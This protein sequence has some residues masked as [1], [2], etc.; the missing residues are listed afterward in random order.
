[1]PQTKEET[2]FSGNWPMK[3]TFLKVHKNKEVFFK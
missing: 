2:D 1:M 3:T